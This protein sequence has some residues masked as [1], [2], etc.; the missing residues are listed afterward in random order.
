[1]TKKAIGS[2]E[3]VTCSDLAFKEVI[4]SAVMIEGSSIRRL[5]QEHRQIMMVA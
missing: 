5:E 2:V 3:S 4:S 1:M